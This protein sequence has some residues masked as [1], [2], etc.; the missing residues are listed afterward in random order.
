MSESG[1]EAPLLLPCKVE[2]GKKKTKET[3]TF[4]PQRLCI[5]FEDEEIS[6]K[7]IVTL[8][9]EKFGGV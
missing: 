4:D 8:A 2:K 3:V 6:I 7:D 1:L 9:L 5:K